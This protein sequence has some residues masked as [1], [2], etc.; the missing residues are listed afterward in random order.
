MAVVAV[1]IAVVAATF[2]IAV[3]AVT[4]V[5]FVTFVTAITPAIT[6]AWSS[7]CCYDCKNVN[8]YT[9]G[10]GQICRSC[11]WFCK[12]N[13][14]ILNVV[15]VLT[16]FH[17]GKVQSRK[18]HGN[19]NGM[20]RTWLKVFLSATRRIVVRCS[21]FLWRVPLVYSGIAFVLALRLLPSCGASRIYIPNL[22]W[23]AHHL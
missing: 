18:K 5:T 17:R 23:C 6:P 22:R 9:Q 10:E 12:G 4:F 13:D 16:L 1:S 19:S 3:V 20:S 11:I 15:F 8:L 21:G 14:L 7:G 2:V